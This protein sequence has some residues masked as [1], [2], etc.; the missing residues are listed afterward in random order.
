MA[1]LFDRYIRLTLHSRPT[2]QQVQ[3][4]VSDVV[5]TL[6]FDKHVISANINKSDNWE[7][8][9]TGSIT[10]NNISRQEA[11]RIISSENP[12]NLYY[13]LVVGYGGRNADN[14]LLSEGHIE[15]VSYRHESGNIGLDLSVTEGNKN[16]RDPW[17][18]GFSP[19]VLS[20]GESLHSVLSRIAG[21]GVTV[22]Y[23][24]DLEFIEKDLQTTVLDEDYIVQ[25]NLAKDLDT[26]LTYKGYQYT[27][28]NRKIVIYEEPL[29]SPQEEL[30]QR[31]ISRGRIKTDA[32][33]VLNFKTGLLNGAIDGVFNF[34]TKVTVPTLT[35]SSLYIPQLYPTQLVELNADL[36]EHFKG[37]YFIR[38]C[39][40]SLNNRSGS[41]QVDG[42][43]ININFKDPNIRD[44]R[45]ENARTSP[46]VTG[47]T[48]TRNLLNNLPSPRS[49]L[50]N[51]FR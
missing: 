24:G 2:T 27:V 8:D 51:L 49:F 28:D 30:R 40:Y 3:A 21:K 31:N 34:Q 17:S 50:G 36:G 16:L 35:F 44:T 39:G 14:T 37:V 41:F 42:S 9:N 48:S 6:V 46:A 47:F 12:R 1:N 19:A 13:T 4:G 26:L 15:T 38:S 11:S 5:S 18:A 25:G 22:Q 43:A 23:I 10:V 29:F 45:L 32:L 33:T 7:V 20:K